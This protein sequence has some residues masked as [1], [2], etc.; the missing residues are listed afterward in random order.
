MWTREESIGSA[1][2]FLENIQFLFRVLDAID[3]SALRQAMGDRD[4]LVSQS[5]IWR[6]LRE[7]S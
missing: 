4:I 5:L 6:A 1:K 3:D 2:Q 7:T